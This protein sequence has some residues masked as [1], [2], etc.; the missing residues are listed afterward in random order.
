MFYLII[1]VLLMLLSGFVILDRSQVVAAIGLIVG[2]YL[3]K[4]GREKMK[5]D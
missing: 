2:I 3:I 5:K 4:I 1:G